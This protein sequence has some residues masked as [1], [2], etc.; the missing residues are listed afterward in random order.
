M[1]ISDASRNSN[2]GKGSLQCD[3]G[4]FFGN[5]WYRFVPPAGT[6]MS[7]QPIPANHCGTEM[8]GWI[9]G[10][11]PSNNGEIVKRNICFVNLWN[12]NTC[13][14]SVSVEIQN[15]GSFYLYKLPNPPNCVSRYCAV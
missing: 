1:E 9:N 15:C 2:F 12:K 4:H 8:T 10:T 14:R 7:E 13:W 11:H 6:Q 3:T 5:T